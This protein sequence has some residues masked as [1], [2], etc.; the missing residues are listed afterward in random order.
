MADDIRDPSVDWDNIDH[1]AISEFLRKKG[2]VELLAL[3][4]GIG[5]RFDEI[6]KA[7]NISRGYINDRRDEALNLD[8]IYPDREERDGSIRRVWA[9]TPLG[10]CVSYLMRHIGVPQSHD[11]L[12]SARTEYNEKKDEFMRWADNPKQIERTTEE[13][14]ETKKRWA[15]DLAPE[16]RKRLYENDDKRF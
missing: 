2:A 7:L 11:R 13:M 8:L 6:D 10:L 9:L 1:V 16:K 3:L 14:K 15:R 12:R 5:F 4:D